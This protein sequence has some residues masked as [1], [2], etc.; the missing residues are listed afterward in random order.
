MFFSAFYL[1]RTAY[2]RLKNCVVCF[3]AAVLKP[4]ESG[5]FPGVFGLSGHSGPAPETPD[6]SAPEFFS[7]LVEC[8]TCHEHFTF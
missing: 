7:L 4:G 5:L 6:F 2:A 3:S 1:L 8:I